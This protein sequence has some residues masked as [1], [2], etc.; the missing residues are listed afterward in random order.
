[1]RIYYTLL[2]QSV[3]LEAA[4]ARI[5]TAE[6]NLDIEWACLRSLRT[7]FGSNRG[8]YGVKCITQRRIHR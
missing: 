2:R 8:R 6:R 1:M 5:Y 3:A 7:E 4:I